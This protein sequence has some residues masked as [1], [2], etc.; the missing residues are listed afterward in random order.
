MQRVMPLGNASCK[1][2]EVK[3]LEIVTWDCEVLYRLQ[4]ESISIKGNIV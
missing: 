1:C 4:Q 3:Q 2:E